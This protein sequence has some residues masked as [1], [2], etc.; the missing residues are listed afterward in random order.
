[1]VTNR[2]GHGDAFDA[3]R[4]TPQ[5]GRAGDRLYPGAAGDEYELCQSVGSRDG[6]A[7]GKRRDINVNGCVRLR[8]VRFGAVL[9]LQSSC[10][11]GGRRRLWLVGCS[12]ADSCCVD[13]S[14]H[15]RLIVSRDVPRSVSRDVS[16][17]RSSSSSSCKVPGTAFSRMSV[18]APAAETVS[19]TTPNGCRYNGEVLLMA[20]IAP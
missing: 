13:A 6:D 4:L 20:W 18:S 5:G 2:G 15:W 19:C 1:M 16:R 9:C 8:C 11:I 17:H 12:S 10:C 14:G 3:V 7:V